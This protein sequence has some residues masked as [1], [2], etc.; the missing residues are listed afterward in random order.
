MK[1]KAAFF[2]VFLIFLSMACSRTKSECE[3]DDAQ[4]E[5]YCFF[6][7]AKEKNDSAKCASI[8]LQSTANACYSSIGIAKKDV[9]VC[10]KIM[11]IEEKNY[12]MKSIS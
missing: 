7:L 2:M 10:D 9:A 3:M 1:G 6:Q 5:D 11:D 4:K 8:K 12:C